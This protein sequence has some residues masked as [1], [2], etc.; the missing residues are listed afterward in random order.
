MAGKNLLVNGKNNITA[1]A[2]AM[3]DIQNTMANRTTA[4]NVNTTPNL[5]TPT[6]PTTVNL[7]KAQQPTQT[8]LNNLNSATLPTTRGIT[9]NNPAFVNGQLINQNNSRFIG[10]QQPQPTTLNS[11]QPQAKSFNKL[12]N[13]WYTYVPSAV[14]QAETANFREENRYRTAENALLDLQWDIYKNQRKLTKR[15]ILLNYPEFKDKIDT[16]MKVQDEL[17][18]INKAGQGV[19]MEQ[20]EINYPELIQPKNIQDIDQIKKQSEQ[21]AKEFENLSKHITKAL[22]TDAKWYSVN[23]LKYLKD[24]DI[25]IREVEKYKKNGVVWWATDKEILDY[26]IKQNPELQK[27]YDEMNSLELSWKDK[28]RLWKANSNVI[29]SMFEDI[30]GSIRDAAYWDH[31]R[32]TQ[33]ELQEMIDAKSSE[34]WGLWS[35]IKTFSPTWVDKIKEYVT[36]WTLDF[37][38]D[39]LKDYIEKETGISI[40]KSAMD[41]GKEM[42]IDA[43]IQEDEARLEERKN[44]Y[45]DPTKQWYYERQSI[46][47][48]LAEWDFAGAWYKMKQSVAENPSM[49]AEMWVMAIN[50]AI[51]MAVMWSDVYM[52]ENQ[53]AYKELKDLGATH[54]EAEAGAMIVWWVNA[55]VELFMERVLWGAERAWATAFRRIFLKNAQKELIKEMQ[56]ASTKSMIKNGVKEYINGSS[57][58]WLEEVVQTIVSN[59]AKQTYDENQDLFEWVGQAFEWWFYNPMNAIGWVTDIAWW[60]RDNK[61]NIKNAAYQWAYNLGQQTRNVVDSTKDFLDLNQ[62][63]NQATQ[64]INNKVKAKKVKKSEDKNW[65][66]SEPEKWI[67]SKVVWWVTNIWSKFYENV[68]EPVAEKWAEVITSTTTPQDK[69]FQ[70][71]SP[72]LNKLTN[73]RWNY[74]QK[75]QNANRTNELIVEYG[76]QPTNTAE[77]Y[78]ALIE[79]KQALWKDEIQRGLDEHQYTTTN[80]HD[81][82]DA[83]REEMSNDSK[84]PLETNKSD[85]DLLE[86]E[87]ANLINLADKNG[88]ISL[89][90]LEAIKQQINAKVNYWKN[91]TAWEVYEKWLRALNSKISEI[92]D[93]M[94]A[95]LP[96][97]F[98]KF[99]KDYG[100]LKDMEED[101]LKMMLKDMKKKSWWGLIQNRWRIEWLGKITTKPVEWILQFMLWESLGKAKDVNFLIQKWFEDLKSQYRGKRQSLD[102]KSNK[103]TTPEAPTETPKNKVTSKKKAEK[104]SEKKEEKKAQQPKQEVKNK[105]TSQ[106]IEEYINETPQDIDYQE[107]A[108][109]ENQTSQDI[110]YQELAEQEN[111]TPQREDEEQV[112]NKVTGQK[113]AATSKWDDIDQI[114][115]IVNNKKQGRFVISEETQAGVVNSFMSTNIQLW[116]YA[117][118]I[119]FLNEW[120][121]DRMTVRIERDNPEN[122]IDKINR[123]LSWLW[124]Q[125]RVVKTATENKW[126][127]LK[128]LNTWNVEQFK[129]EANYWD[130]TKKLK[131]TQIV[132]RRTAEQQAEY[133][134]ELEEKRAIHKAHQE[135]SDLERDVKKNEQ[136]AAEAKL[137]EKR[138][139]VQDY[140]DENYKA[141]IARTRALSELTKP[142]YEWYVSGKWYVRNLHYYD[143]PDDTEVWEALNDMAKYDGEIRE[144]REREY[145][146]KDGEHHDVYNYF[147]TYKSDPENKWLTNTQLTKYQRDYLSDKLNKK[148]MEAEKKDMEENPDKYVT[149]E[150]AESLFQPWGTKVKT[151][152]EKA[153][154]REIFDWLPVE[155]DEWWKFVRRS[156]NWLPPIK[157]YIWQ[158]EKKAENIDLDNTS[159]SKLEKIIQESGWD[160]SIEKVNGTNDY[161]VYYQVDRSTTPYL[162]VIEN[163]VVD[164]NEDEAK[165]LRKLSE[166]ESKSEWNNVA[167]TLNNLKSF[168]DLGKIFELRKPT[169]D[170]NKYPY[171]HGILNDVPVMVRDTWDSIHIRYWSKWEAD[172]EN[173]PTFRWAKARV[174]K[175]DKDYMQQLSELLREINNNWEILE[176]N[177]YPSKPQTTTEITWEKTAATAKQTQ[178]NEP[179]NKVTSE[180]VTSELQELADKNWLLEYDGNTFTYRYSWSSYYTQE[181]NPVMEWENIK[182]LR[183]YQWWII[184]DKHLKKAFENWFS[185]EINWKTINKDNYWQAVND[186]DDLVFYT[187]RKQSYGTDLDYA[188][189]IP[190]QDF[191]KKYWKE[192]QRLQSVDKKENTNIIGTNNTLTTNNTTNAT[193]N[194]WENEQ[195]IWWSTEISRWAVSPKISDSQSSESRSNIQEQSYSNG[196]RY[197]NTSMNTD[198][199]LG[200]GSRTWWTQPVLSRAEQRKV[201]QDARSILEKH[202]FSQNRID[203]SPDELATLF[204]FEWNGGLANAEDEDIKGSR[205]EFYTPEAPTS[206]LQRGIQKYSD[207]PITK[208]IDPTGWKWNLFNWIADTIE[209]EMYEINKVSWT[210]AK[211]RFPEMTVHIGETDWDYQNRFKDFMW[212]PT[213]TPTNWSLNA[214]AI[215]W[216][217][218]FW[219]RI[220][221]RDDKDI[222]RLEEYFVKRPIEVDLQDGGV[223]WYVMP[224]TWLRGKDNAGKKRLAENTEIVDAYRLPAG[225]FSYT[226]VGTDLIIIKKVKPEKKSDFFYDNNYFK[227]HPEKVLGE[228][229]TRLRWFWEEIYVEWDPKVVDTL[230]NDTPTKQTVVETPKNKVTSNENTKITAAPQEVEVQE[231]QWEFKPN[232]KPKNAVTSKPKKANTVKQWKKQPKITVYKWD[233]TDTWTYTFWDTE[234]LKVM[235]AIN[236]DWYVEPSK[237]WTTLEQVKQGVK[238]VNYID[239]KVQP[240]FLYFA[241]DIYE[242]LDLLEKDKEWMSDAQYQK[243]KDWLKAVMPPRRSLQDIEFSVLDE[244]LMATETNQIET[245][246]LRNPETWRWEDTNVKL[247]I[248]DLFWKYMTWDW[249][250]WS[251]RYKRDWIFQWTGTNPQNVRDYY[252]GRKNMKKEDQW[253]AKERA[254]VLFN[255]FIK[256]SL[257]DEEKQALEDKYNKD[258]VAV[259]RPN[260]EDM[261]IQV[262]DMSATFHGQPLNLSPIQW[263]WV[264]AMVSKWSMNI[265]HWVG[266]GKTLEWVTATEIVLQRWWV[267]RPLLIV[268]K[269]TKKDW[270]KTYNEAFPNREVV[271]LWGLLKADI[272]RLT[273]EFGADPRNWL[274]DGQVWI[275]THS[276]FERNLSFKKAWIDELTRGLRDVMESKDESWNKKKKSA[277]KQD[278]EQEKLEATAEETAE[279]KSRN[280]KAM[281]ALAKYNPDWLKDLTNRYEDWTYEEFKQQ[282]KDRFTKEKVGDEEQ[283]YFDNPYKI[284]VAEDIMN[285]DIDAMWS[286][287]PV[288]VEDLG[289]D[290]IVVDE[291]HNFKNIFKSAETEK[292]EDWNRVRDNR[293]WNVQGS[294]SARG[295]KMYSLTQYIL[296]NNWW[297]W[298]FSLSATPF[299]NQALEVYNILSLHAYNRLLEMWIRNI[300]DFFGKFSDFKEDLVAKANGTFEFKDIMVSFKNVRELQ[301]LLLEYMDYRADNPDL[302]RP[303]SVV[304]KVELDMSDLQQDVQDWIEAQLND[305]QALK[306]NPWLMLKLIW[307]MRLNLI[308]PY[309]TENYKDIIP[310][311]Q[312]LIASSPKLKFSLDTIKRLRDE[313]NNDWV[314]IYMPYMWKDGVLHNVLKEAIENYVGAD[315]VNV[316]II[317]WKTTWSVKD[318]DGESIDKKTAIANEFRSWKLNVLIWWENTVEWIN[319]QDEWYITIDL[320]LGWN[321][322]LTTQLFGRVW[323]QWNLR[324]HTIQLLPLIRNSWD[325]VMLQKFLEKSSR[326]NDLL[327]FQWTLFNVEDLDSNEE[328]LALLTDINKKADLQILLDDKKYQK[329]DQKLVSQEEQ[330]QKVLDKE[331]KD[332]DL[333]RVQER[334]DKLAEEVEKYKTALDAIPEDNPAYRSVKSDL[335]NAKYRLE[336]ERKDLRKLKEQKKYVDTKLQQYNVNSIEE[337]RQKLQEIWQQRQDIVNLRAWLKESRPQVVQKLREERDEQMKNQKSY[338]EYLDDMSYLFK[339]KK[340]F[341]TRAELKAW[342]EKNK[343]DRPS[344]TRN[345]V[346]SNNMNKITSK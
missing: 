101:V 260:Y 132:P 148:K 12:M 234:Q 226:D 270:I 118:Q 98:T 107:L 300:N 66:W 313:W 54:D 305:E 286:M 335:D 154:E 324:N 288:Y 55:A 191:L 61:E 274:K 90:I 139:E 25:L 186:E 161:Q 229:K 240:D 289:I 342:L 112:K 181:W 155:E 171:Y 129:E 265:A 156:V 298:V 87:F 165:L 192:I 330:I 85:L 319:L 159:K 82:I 46:T 92:E 127:G 62:K 39:N 172:S 294:S 93:E 152:W 37:S 242:K 249:P 166:W 130:I 174:D 304:K 67:V 188:G 303:E 235:E 120:D 35:Q 205:Y 204:K 149:D 195:G 117:N 158:W 126:F 115:D 207:H 222:K 123:V 307:Q 209:K 88:D 18:P 200:D 106:K 86:K 24:A 343:I 339:Q 276:W 78:K 28:A 332:D 94:I 233:K 337:L 201:N 133:E 72:T 241:W 309:L 140:V 279:T 218:P 31:F 236:P 71:V 203:Y 15:E 252:T 208:I 321:P 111:E 110:D 340:K 121:T 135:L 258:Y 170:E 80:I 206:A 53:E 147:Y 59:A 266:Y 308:S 331:V 64:D 105:V 26:A 232:E 58:E 345:A 68:V 122:Y 230:W 194:W 275:L 301:R 163:K 168:E 216:N 283:W 42:M 287:R 29:R 190:L 75:R 251:S 177:R 202:W 100:A 36:R 116:W 239:W 341:G 6:R 104:K 47:E 9:T 108:E 334:V 16:I 57:V 151:E 259:V 224:S 97:E 261:P 316:G 238:W 196:E 292:N 237:I 262:K 14:S 128:N 327:S 74:E 136:R 255:D 296:Q 290:H 312:E 198:S 325:I 157:Q 169:K 278:E 145:I 311:R 45:L 142:I 91:P 314:F 1:R 17:L 164:I 328:R 51:W 210:I 33:D 189:R 56:N 268:P 211:L 221:A 50:P 253:P 52:Q 138:K 180:Q 103:P 21:Q 273:D 131:N 310:T 13:W 173:R 63:R 143:M 346:T 134:K 144:V 269:W 215:I 175:F 243:Q 179:K 306:D 49:I 109:M 322:T 231:P 199:I 30:R 167:D 83:V 244:Q 326:I 96:W 267:K 185:F 197:A 317:N 257:P 297:R 95:E 248:D 146:D 336:T 264:K 214:S 315:R 285:A 225:V 282:F 183:K 114:L 184:L 141:W 182:I 223:A 60:I 99:K 44:K 73:K 302:V 338:D 32:Y 256:N 125:Y 119:M 220:K 299:N 219:N 81:I 11:L 245:R 320:L 153:A 79:T 5:P 228:E 150:E 272:K 27:V 10:F 20:F 22:T 160:F 102:V 291:V 40:P 34:K 4:S 281:I 48:L 277:R 65:W 280:S 323:R 318:E 250:S 193:N 247:T 113:T 329:E 293:F 3:A 77:Y 187:G 8:K 162:P 227:K 263:L 295:R 137:K 69:L 23:G 212:K 43:Q 254:D 344:D 38:V 176:N 217:P 19:D 84:Y 213:K 41:W 2:N 178:D 124:L 246:N 271:D 70:A 333:Q 76:K 89:E 284:D 7:Q